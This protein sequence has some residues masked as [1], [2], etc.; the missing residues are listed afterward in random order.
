M[1]CIPTKGFEKYIDIKYINKEYKF[2]KLITARA[3][4]KANSGF[5][6]MFI[7]NNSVH[8]KSYISF[9]VTTENEAKSLLSYMKCK[10]PNFMLSL[11]KNSQDISENTCKWIPLPPLDREWNDNEIYKYFKLSNNNIKLIKETK[12]I[13]YKDIIEIKNKD[14]RYNL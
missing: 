3:A 13:G 10:L 5:G 6:N 12:I 9:G 11:R 1:L 2:W 4:H 8:S 7:D 14:L